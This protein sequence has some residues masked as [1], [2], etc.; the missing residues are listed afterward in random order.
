[1]RHAGDAQGNGQVFGQ[2]RDFAEPQA[3]F[4]LDLELR[5]HRPGLDLD[6]FDV[7]AE[8]EERLFQDLGLAANVLLVLLEMDRL[9]FDQHVDR[10]Q[11][12]RAVVFG[13]GGSVERGHHFL[14]LAAL[15][16]RLDAQGSRGGLGFV[17]LGIGGFGVLGSFI[18]GGDFVFGGGNFGRS[19]LVD[20]LAANLHSQVARLG[21]GIIEIR[22]RR[23]RFVVALCHGAADARQPAPRSAGRHAQHQGRRPEDQIVTAQQQSTKQDTENHDVSTGRGQVRLQHGPPDGTQVS[24]RPRH[25]SRRQPGDGHGQQR[26]QPRK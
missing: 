12:V 18:V 9:P 22:A 6:D 20:G 15:D 23:G 26:R 1:M 16:G 24:A 19:Q 14:P 10:R 21:V 17:G 2:A 3:G 5:D 8:I 7:E 25:R 4:E 13:P 11:L